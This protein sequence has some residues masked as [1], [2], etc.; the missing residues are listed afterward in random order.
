MSQTRWTPT[1]WTVMSA[2]AG[3][4]G[5]ALDS[6]LYLPADLRVIPVRRCV[7]VPMRQIAPGTY[8]ID[9][10]GSATRSRPGAAWQRVVNE[11]QRQRLERLLDWARVGVIGLHDD[12]PVPV[13]RLIEAAV[14]RAAGRPDKCVRLPH[15]PADWRARRDATW[16]PDRSTDTPGS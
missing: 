11:H 6:A 10:V 8:A 16:R 13:V 7:Y 2:Q 12:T 15:L 9:Y 3:P 5:S 14:A 1:L 4:W